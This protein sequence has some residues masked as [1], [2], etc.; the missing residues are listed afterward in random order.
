MSAKA[1]NNL[2]FAIETDEGVRIEYDLASPVR[3]M[4]AILVDLCCIS[5]LNS[6]I[7][8]LLMLFA[9]I[10]SS[11]AS[12]LA[13]IL[14]FVVTIGY[15]IVLEWSWQGQTVG[16]RLLRLRVMDMNGRKLVPEQVVLRNLLRVIDMMPGVYLFGGTVAFL[17]RNAQR[18]GDIAAGTVVIWHRERSMPALPTDDLVKYNS[19]HHYPHLEA[20]LR[21]L[22]APAE[23]DTLIHALHRRKQLAPSE[24][25]ALFDQFANDLKHLCPFPIDAYENVSSEQYVRNCLDSITRQSRKMAARK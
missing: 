22:L 17:N 5:A 9:I 4:L 1:D 18:L 6:A 16:K 23:V 3:R 24:R 12:A 2:R 14:Q 21:Q 7:T 20:R 25:I 15:G 19:L 10:S 8:T 13:I 11:T